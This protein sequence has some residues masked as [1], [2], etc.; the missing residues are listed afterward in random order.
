MDPSIYY[1]DAVQGV[2]DLFQYLVDLWF[3][4]KYG[5]DVCL[6]YFNRF[7]YMDTLLGMKYFPDIRRRLAR[8]L[9][10]MILLWVITSLYDYLV[11]AFAYGP[12]APLFF[13]ANYVHMCIKSLTNLHLS[14]NITH[15]EYRLRTIGDHVQTLYAGLENLPPM[16]LSRA[17]CSTWFC[18]YSKDSGDSDM[19]FSKARK[20]VKLFKSYY[21]LL[22]EQVKFINRMFGMRILLN[23]LSFLI[24]MVR[25]INVAAR[26]IIIGSQQ[27]GTERFY[28]AVGSLVKLLM[29]AVMLVSIVWRSEQAYEQRSRLLCLIDN[30][31]VHKDIDENIVD[32]IKDFHDL[33]E[34]RPVSFSMA[35]FVRIDNTFLV[36]MASA[37]V[38]YSII[39]LQNVN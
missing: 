5:A 22:S 25:L 7:C 32:D 3:V 36:S 14:L 18:P 19:E 34:A 2:Y 33:V 38:T 6:E 12:V 23:T 1:M 26:V 28:P 35:D 39:L 30:L 8:F 9:C 13:S 29:C 17:L 24:D 20:N 16:T 10:L 27:M 15:V 11:W 4:Y 37:V 31:L 21:L